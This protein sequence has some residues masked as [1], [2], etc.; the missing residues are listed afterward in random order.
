MGLVQQALQEA[1][2]K[3]SD[4]SCIAYT[5]VQPFSSFLHSCNS[6]SQT[7]HDRWKGAQC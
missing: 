7:A 4:I 1:K 6:Q 2:V 5:K 3:A